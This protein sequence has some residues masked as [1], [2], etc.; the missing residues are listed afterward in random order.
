MQGKIRVELTLTLI[1]TSLVQLAG[2]AHARIEVARRIH[3]QGCVVKWPI[4]NAFSTVALLAIPV[5]PEPVVGLEDGR[6]VQQLFRL[7]LQLVPYDSLKSVSGNV[8]QIGGAR[9]RTVR[10]SAFVTTLLLKRAFQHRDK[11]AVEWQEL[12]AIVDEV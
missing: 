8:S 7:I 10:E 2:D 5:T 12:A 1:P 6:L 3:D 9:V 4:R 11:P